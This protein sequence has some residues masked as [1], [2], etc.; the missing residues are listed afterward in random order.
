MSA[1]QALKRGPGNPKVIARK[2]MAGNPISIA[3]RT[4]LSCGASF[5]P[6]TGRQRNCGSKNVEGTCAYLANQRLQKVTRRQKLNAYQRE[7]YQKNKVVML[8]DF[9]KSYLLNRQKIIERNKKTQRPY[10]YKKKYGITVDDYNRM[11]QEQG[12][13]CKIC[14]ETGDSKDGRRKFLCV[15]HCHKT[16]KVR[17]LLCMKCNTS[18]GAFEK[19]REQMLQYLISAEQAHVS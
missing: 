6:S 13:K 8:S 7:Y 2:G 1:V 16:G 5:Q 4:C 15:D 17:G 19:Y 11:L 12:G 10:L 14:N 18:L 9:K 3:D